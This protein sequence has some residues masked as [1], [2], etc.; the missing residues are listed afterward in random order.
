MTFVGM[1]AAMSFAW[2]S[3]IGSAVSDPPPL[4]AADG[5]DRV[6]DLDPGLDRRVH[7]LAGDDAR[8]HDVDRAE[9]L[10]D[11][12]A[13]AVERAAQGIDDAADELRPD[14]RLDD[15]AGRADLAALLDA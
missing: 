7:V 1:Y 2:V 11:D 4:A 14:A 6:D 3:M 10:R 13:L 8:R 12:V 9:L 15:P 5:R